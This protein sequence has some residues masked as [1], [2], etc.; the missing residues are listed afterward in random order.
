MK[1]PIREKTHLEGEANLLSFLQYRND[2]STKK[3]ALSRE[4]PLMCGMY[5]CYKIHPLL[6]FLYITTLR[7]SSHP[8]KKI[9]C[10]RT[11]PLLLLVAWYLK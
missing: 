2:A 4:F 5:G 11:K 3:E 10:K 6:L 9:Q 8:W 7:C 1:S